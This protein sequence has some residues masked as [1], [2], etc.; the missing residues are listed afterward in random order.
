MT[1][2]M[3]LEREKDG[4]LGTSDALLLWPTGGTTED[5]RRSRGGPSPLSRPAA[6]VLSLSALSAGRATFVKVMMH[7][8]SSPP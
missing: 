7:S 4:K 5:A 8:I 6:G 1:L 3:E 2:A